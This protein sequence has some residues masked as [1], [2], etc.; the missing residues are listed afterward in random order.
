MPRT[1]IARFI[2]LAFYL[3][4]CSGCYTVAITP[5]QKRPEDFIPVKARIEIPERTRNYTISFRSWAAGVANRW[6]VMVGDAV[7]RYSDAY[8]PSLFPA[9][10]DVRVLIEVVDFKVRDFR[11]IADMKFTVSK[12]GKNLFSKAYHSEGTSRAGA[13]VWGGVFAMKGVVSSTM[14]EVFKDIFS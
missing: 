13:A 12:Q 2:A 10:D 1:Q 4:V 5:V 14:H 3:T 6:K 11:S 9:G 8:V 7:V